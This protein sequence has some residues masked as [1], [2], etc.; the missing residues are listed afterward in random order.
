[1]I[2]DM[3]SD[4]GYAITFFQQEG[5]AIMGFF[6]VDGPLYKF[7]S[8]LLDVLKL[9]FLWILFSLPIITIGASTVA[10]YSVALK[11][12][13]EQEGYIG[14]SFI[15]SFKDNWKQG[16]ILGIIGL[17]AGYVVYLNFALFQAIENNPLPLVLVGVFAAVYF[18]GSLLYAFPLM[19]RYQN[20]VLNTMKNSLRISTKYIK[21]TI[22]LLLLVAL[23]VVIFIYNSTTIFFGILIGPAFIIF[24]ISSLSLRV[25]QKIERD[26]AESEN[27]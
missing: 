16:M 24:L 10:A 26:Q 21:R 3:G 14:R 27:Q 5:M 19:A 11:M 9:N 1:M 2:C 17:L 6:N 13:D 15:K 8:R 4:S 7:L 18:V 12:V 22:V 25:F 23:S 20:S